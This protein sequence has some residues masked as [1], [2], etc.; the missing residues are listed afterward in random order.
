M[1][2]EHQER[3]RLLSGEARRVIDKMPDNI[4]KLGHIASLF[5]AARVILCR[6]D[7]RDTCLSCYFTLFASGNLF[8]YDLA[9]CAHRHGE[10]RFGQVG[11]RSQAGR[12]GATSRPGPPGARLAQR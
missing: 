7:P 9:D 5:P 8:S 2:G 1:A 4:F 3:L 11:R 10:T 6:R 12:S